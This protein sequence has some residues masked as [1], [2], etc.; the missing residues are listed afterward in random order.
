MLAISCQCSL[1][2]LQSDREID[3]VSYN[4]H[5]L[6]DAEESGSEY[7]EFKPSKGAWTKEL[8]ARRLSNAVRAVKSF[9][10]GESAPR[11]RAATARAG[12]PDILCLQEIENQQVLADLAE[13]FGRGT[14]AYWAIGGPRNGIIHSGLLSRFP[15]V[16][17]RTHS[18][19]D[20]WGF[21]PMR[22]VLE[23]EVKCGDMGNII[24]FV[25]H[26]KSKMEG[27][28][29]TE[30]ARR[31]AAALLADRI[32]SIETERP[33]VPIV[34]CGDFNESPDE[35]FRVERAYVTGIMP[36]ETSSPSSSPGGAPLCVSNS[37]DELK[38]ASADAVQVAL[39]SAWNEAPGG[40]S[41]AYQEAREQ[42]DSFFLS[43]S[44]QD[45]VGI[46]FEEFRVAD[47]PELFAE[48]GTPFEWRGSQG[49][50]DHLPV[51][52]LLRAESE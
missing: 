35:Y 15:I 1:S 41:I 28:K 22:D 34:V 47:A 4:V 10:S 38:R 40:F 14:Y 51:R 29:E 39:Y 27:A 30:P 48:D 11:V 13:R 44:C 45:G 18:V 23:V 9:A 37:W 26:W 5:N 49:F 20:A 12:V 7:P 52:L 25:C 50:S 6:F 8:Y 36:L 43:A 16:A 42:F 33:G 32:R 2:T 21:G 24:L 17:L 46:E 31:A 3:I 19:L